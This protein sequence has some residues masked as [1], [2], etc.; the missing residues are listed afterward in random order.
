MS[1]TPKGKKGMRRKLMQQQ[2]TTINEVRRAM[3]ACSQA[4]DEQIAEIIALKR[5]VIS[6]RAQVIF[7]SEKY[8]SCLKHECLDLSPIDFLKLSAEKQ[9]PFVRRAAEELITNGQPIAPFD[10]DVSDFPKV[11]K[12]LILPN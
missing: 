2:A 11:A 10:P 1:N 6:E 7:Y 9:E 5:V 4:L 8:V 12:T 3:L